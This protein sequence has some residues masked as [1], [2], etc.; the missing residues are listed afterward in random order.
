MDLPDWMKPHEELWK[1]FIGHREDKKKPLNERA[2]KMAISK[3]KRYSEEGCSIQEM[4]ETAILKDWDGI[5]PVYIYQKKP[6]QPQVSKP[7][8]HKM[9]EPDRSVKPASKEAVSAAI[10]EARAKMHVVSK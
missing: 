5:W 8:S 7:A 1:D 9:Y 6:E 3:L 4:I 10:A 2:Q